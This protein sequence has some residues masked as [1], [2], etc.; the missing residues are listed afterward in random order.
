MSDGPTCVELTCPQYKCNL[1]IPSAT[2][3]EL[4]HSSGQESSSMDIPTM[5]R[6]ASGCLVPMGSKVYESFIK[7]LVKNFIEQ[8]SCM[9]W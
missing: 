1:R 3:K 9:R 4:C 5:D 6:T 2:V 7:H 8:S